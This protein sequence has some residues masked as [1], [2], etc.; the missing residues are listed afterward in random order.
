MDT[1]MI[2]D[3]VSQGIMLISAEKYD[4]AK[5]VFEEIISE[6]PR[7]L[8][9][10]IHLGNACANLEQYSEAIEAFKKA[11]LVDPNY[12]EAYFSIGSIY[13]LMNEKVKAVEFYNKAE[14]NGFV[15]SQMYQIMASIFFEAEDE[16]Q[17]L[18]NISRAI[19]LN[20]F[21]GELRLLKTKIY[22]AFNRFEQALESLDEMEKVL[23][24]SFDIYDVKSQI[25]LGQER[26][27]EALEVINKGCSRFPKDY[28]LANI[29]LKILIQS[30]LDAEAHKWIDYMKSEGLFSNVIKDASINEATLLIKENKIENAC[31]AL[32][33]A[34]NQVGDDP[35]LLYL[36]VD[37]YGKTAQ[38]EKL[39]TYSA[40]LMNEEYGIFYY[41]TALFFH[42]TA[43]EATGNV[44]EA[45]K[46]FK[47]ITIKMRKATI[48]DPSFYEGYLYRLL[49][50]VKIK[51]YDKALDLAEYI[52]NL[53]PE[54]ADAHAFRY[55]IF[56]EM[57]N[58]EEAKKERDLAKS[59]N[60]NL[61]IQ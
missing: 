7:T 17:A 23:P 50:H 26:Y 35:D 18:R 9:A 12:A 58:S 31:K 16:P 2:N 49:S 42:A 44:S 22:L 47:N 20:P 32:L 4:A 61:D 27:T 13:V 29:K 14:E 33:E 25:L 43:L 60:P 53:Y 45:K 36:I 39:L 3:K 41:S 10:Y 54:K 6:A 24:D 59:M 30:N 5:K 37:I 57:G 21:N 56:K 52:E 8:E 1:E 11:L 46:E 38:N 15:S 55:F 28:N 48:N 34:N 40:K 19:N 51:E